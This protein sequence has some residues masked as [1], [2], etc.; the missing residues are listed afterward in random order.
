MIMIDSIF[1]YLLYLL[2]IVFFFLIGYIAYL[3]ADR[4]YRKGKAG[5]SWVQIA[6]CSLLY[7]FHYLICSNGELIR[8]KAYYAYRFLSGQDVSKESYGLDW[9]YK[10]LRPIISDTEFLFFI[11]TTVYIGLSFVSY[12]YYKQRNPLALLL[13]L[14]SL[15]G[16]WATILKQEISQA[17]TGIS[18]MLFFNLYYVGFLKKVLMCAVMCIFIVAGI[19]FHEAAYIIPLV[20]FAMCFLHL[21]FIRYF[22][23]A[24]ITLVLVLWSHVQNYLYGSIGTYSEELAEQTY[25]YTSD[26]L[27]TGQS[28]LTIVKGLPFYILVLVAILKRRKYVDLI[29][30]YDKYLF[31]VVV[32]S[33]FI[34]LSAYNY[35]YFRFSLYF[36]LPMFIFATQ[37]RCIMRANRERTLWFN[38]FCFITMFLAFKELA[39][40]Y[41]YTGGL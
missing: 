18:M 9:S 32:S 35:W 25:S 33:V 22:I 2:K 8:D 27:G 17:L 38:W 19:L 28:S 1:L 5:L 39:Q 21:N 10:L 3:L 15:Y 13:L 36:Y 11:F 40:Y 29:P 7:G 14:T 4:N 31:L 6:I 12:R 23:F 41:L 20:L 26:G 37:L 34:L 24:A 16:L 30:N